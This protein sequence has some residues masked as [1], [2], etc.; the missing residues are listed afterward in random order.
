LYPGYNTEVFS[1]LRTVVVLEIQGISKTFPGVKALDGV[2]ISVKKG[3]VHGL[4]G[5]NGAGKSTLMHILAGVFPPN[6]GKIILNGNELE[7]EDERSAQR[8]GIGMVFQERSLVGEMSIAE[9]IFAGRQPVKR[10][11]LVDWK[12]MNEQASDLLRQVGLNLDPTIKV[13]RLSTIEKQL[14]EI[15]KAL[16]LDAKVLILDEP[17]ATITERETDILFALVC[18]LRTR[19]ISIIY[20]SHRLQELHSICDRVSVLKDGVF[21]GTRNL[22]EV[23]TSEIVTM[24]VG[25]EVL[26]EYDDRGNDK[27]DVVLEVKNLSSRAFKNV[28]F[29]LR[30]QEILGIAGLAGAGRTEIALAIFGADQKATGEIYLHGKKTKIRSP[31]EAI[32]NGIGYLTEDRKDAG[33]FLDLDV[34]SNIASAN[35]REFSQNGFLN[36][37]EIRK[38]TGLSVENLQISTPSLKQKAINL[39]GGNQ[40]KLLMARWL[41]RESDIL[42]IDEPTHGVDVG[43]K[44]E[45]Y[46]LIRTMA[47]S[48]TSIIVISSE[49]PEILMLCDRMVIMWQGNLTGELTHNEAT[50]EKIMHFASGLNL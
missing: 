18:E 20:I 12:S 46:D 17:T 34:S 29:T 38:Q 21:Q 11:N 32:R 45:I 39:S 16:S 36:D 19:G 33:L 28:S 35:L 15:A 6:E 4:V 43:A 24:M 14:V 41:M 25:R 8:A 42:I 13:F 30:K 3:E 49:L 22:G 23:N 5:E 37:Q 50:E 40:Q 31:E 7:F 44:S 47:K 10:F 26:N 2:S 48:G 27:S 1:L 9:N